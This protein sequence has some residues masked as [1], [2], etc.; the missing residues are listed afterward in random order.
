MPRIVTITIAHLVI[1]IAS[2][3][4]LGLSAL[5]IGFTEFSATCDVYAVLTLIWQ[6]LNAPAGIYL[7]HSSPPN[8]TIWVGLQLF[9]SFLWANV[10]VLGVSALSKRRHDKP[11]EPTQ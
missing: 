1:T 6:A 9:T 8:W 2:G 10:F 5:G 3:L 11:F 7:L 4:L